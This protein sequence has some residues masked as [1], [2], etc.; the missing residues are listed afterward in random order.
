M[1]IRENQVKISGNKNIV[2]QDC[3]LGNLTIN[4]IDIHKLA[5]LLSRN[6]TVAKIIIIVST[7][8]LIKQEIENKKIKE[9]DISDISDFLS[10]EQKNWKPFKNKNILQILKE[11]QEKS[12]FSIKPIILDS[13]NLNI[14]EYLI[15]EIKYEKKK[16]ILIADGISLHFENNRKIAKVFNDRE[17]G[18]CLL[19]I[20]K[21]QNENIKQFMMKNNLK[22]FS[23]LFRYSNNYS[24]NF[25][26]KKQDKGFIHIDLQVPDKNTI[27]RRLTSIMTLHLNS[28]RHFK[29][30]DAYA[31]PDR[32]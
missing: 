11:F 30:L 16:T 5:K 29:E 4:P 27:F 24:E 21:K 15:D 9:F 12:G 13:G 31:I 17:I 3:E 26:H 14:D 10:N 20:F 8:N 18:G 23:S 2:I 1:E 22:T 28:Q 7:L 25:L 32:L 6:K 19:P